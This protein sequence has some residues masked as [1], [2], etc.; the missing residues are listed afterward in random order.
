[1]LKLRLRGS[2]FFRGG[3]GRRGKGSGG[4]FFKAGCFLRDNDVPYM[5]KECKNAR[6]AKR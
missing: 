6:K 4:R 5:T 3:G 2:F 1:M